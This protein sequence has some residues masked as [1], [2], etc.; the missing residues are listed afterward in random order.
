MIKYPVNQTI[1]RSNSNSQV[2]DSYGN[3][4]P[5]R[6]YQPASTIQTKGTYLIAVVFVLLLTTLIVAYFIVTTATIDT[7]FASLLVNSFIGVNRPSRTYLLNKTNLGNYYIWQFKI[8]T[9]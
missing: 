3:S 2:V 8:F 6:L 4:A 9:C 5:I 7:S 1:E